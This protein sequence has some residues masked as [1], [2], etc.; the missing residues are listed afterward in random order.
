[1]PGRSCEDAPHKAVEDGQAGT[2]ARRDG[3]HGRC[4]HP[5]LVEFDE[6]LAWP[7]GAGG[8]GRTVPLLVRRYAEDGLE[9]PD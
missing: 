6:P 9:L 4:P 2:I 8:L 1:M 5:V 3:P 7:I